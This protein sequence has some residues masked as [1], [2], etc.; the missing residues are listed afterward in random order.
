MEKLAPDADASM[1]LTA[2]TEMR[3]SPPASVLPGLKPNHP[4][5]RMKQPS[6]PIGM[7]WPGIGF[8]EPSLLYLPMRGPRTMAPASAVTPPTMCTTE[9]PAKST[10]P[11]PSPK[12]LPSCESQPPPQTQL[13]KIGYV[14]IDRK[15]PNTTK[16]ENFQRSAI[17]PVGIVAAVSMNTIWK[18]NRVKTAT[19]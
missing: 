4:K 2:M 15:K 14:N 10:W 3:R 8:A 17:A 12:F 11:W 6:T 19:S 1:V 5:A 7:L 18:R 16:D 9:E 13:A